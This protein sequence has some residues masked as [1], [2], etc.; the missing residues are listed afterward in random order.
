MTGALELLRTIARAPLRTMRYRDMQHLGTNT[1]RQLD[2]LVDGGALLR[3]AHGVYTVPPDGRDGR[4][5]QPGLESAGLAVAT[6]RHGDR[7]AILMGIGAARHWGAIPRAIGSTAIAVPTAGHRPV[8]VDAGQIHFVQRDLE[9]VVAVLEQTELGAALVT[10][11]EQTQFDL[12]MRP[13]QGGAPD[14]AYAAARQLQ[15]QVDPEEFAA[16]I[17]D[18]PRVSTAVR[19]AALALGAQR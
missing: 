6:A 19:Q 11:P 7:H 15:P 8:L 4:V 14:T 5:W 13:H 12:L 1:W 10:T 18:A 3:L 9:R 17:S 16:I 2:D